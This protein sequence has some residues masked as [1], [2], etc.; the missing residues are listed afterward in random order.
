VAYVNRHGESGLSVPPGDTRAL[1][2]AL[3][4]I[5]TDDALRQRLA[6]GASRR[7]ASEF[8][9]PALARRLSHVYWEVL[10]QT[11]GH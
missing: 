9:I 8:D 4:R 11:G 6:V 3:N 5:L 1:A 10:G 2:N 7:A